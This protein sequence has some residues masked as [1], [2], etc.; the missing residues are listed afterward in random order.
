MKNKKLFGI[1]AVVLIICVAFAPVINGMQLSTEQENE[2]EIIEGS[3]ASYDLV[4]TIDE[5]TFKGHE[6]IKNV[7]DYMFAVWSLTYTIKNEGNRFFWGKIITE[8]LKDSIKFA[9]YD[10]G[11]HLIKAG[12]SETFSH[13]L[14]IK[15]SDISD[16]DKERYFSA[17]DIVV[18][19]V[20]EDQAGQPDP[21]PSNNADIKFSKYWKTADDDKPSKNHID[22]AVMGEDWVE[23]YEEYNIGGRDIITL[24]VFMDEYLELIKSLFGCNR[25]GWLWGLLDYGLDF[26][27]A[28]CNFLEEFFEVLADIVLILAELE[29]LIAEVIAFF[30]PIMGIPPIYPTKAQIS[31]FLGTLAVLAETIKELLLDI[32]KLPIDPDDPLRIA[33]DEAGKALESFLNSEPWFDD[34]T[35]EGEVFRIYGGEVLTITCRDNEPWTVPENGNPTTFG[36]YEVPTNWQQGDL[37]IFRNCQITVEGSEHNKAVKSPRLLSYCAPGGYMYYHVKLPVGGGN[38]NQESLSQKLVEMC[39]LL[40]Q[41]FPSYF[42]KPLNA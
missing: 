4:I 13:T 41:L 28:L 27:V 38:V 40:T 36:P 26:C 32:E 35:V 17:K 33:L 6:E 20:K 22:L 12:K 25:L 11:R 3:P 37:I 7:D 31:I 30:T 19:T 39:P 1:G 42:L 29:I 9:E 23:K 14:K 24:P 15:A 10:E 21:T 34:V 18:D 8:V 16:I 5:L 2:I